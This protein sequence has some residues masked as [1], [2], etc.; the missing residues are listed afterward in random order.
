M[1]PCIANL[2]S[3]VPIVRITV[4]ALFSACGFTR[5]NSH[6]RTTNTDYT[7]SAVLVPKWHTKTGEWRRRKAIIKSDQV[8]HVKTAH[9]APRSS[10]KLVDFL[11]GKKKTFW[12]EDRNRPLMAGCMVVAPFLVLRGPFR[13]SPVYYINRTVAVSKRKWA[14]RHIHI[15][16]SSIPDYCAMKCSPSDKQTDNQTDIR[17][18]PGKKKIFKYGINTGLGSQNKI[19]GL[20]SVRYPDNNNNFSHMCDRHLSSSGCY[21]RWTSQIRWPRRL[22][23]ISRLPF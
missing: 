12:T 7:R 15:A 5:H 1:L 18:S 10:W 23:R 11:G 4:G 20:S 13:P 6:S 14:W 3:A 19:I 21:W 17:G 22:S 8:R 9:D 16:H 2:I